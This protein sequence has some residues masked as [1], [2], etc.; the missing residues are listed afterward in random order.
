V[1]ADAGDFI[2]VPVILG[3]LAIRWECSAASGVFMGAEMILL[4]IRNTLSNWGT[5]T[6]GAPLPVPSRALIHCNE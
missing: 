2:V 1:S 3:L 5:F 4:G 6:F